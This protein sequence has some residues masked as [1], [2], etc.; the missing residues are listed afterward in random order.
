MGTYGSSGEYITGLASALP[1][2]AS[3][4]T[5]GSGPY[6]HSSEVNPLS[7]LQ[8]PGGGTIADEYYGNSNFNVTLDLTDGNTH[9]VALYAADFDGQNRTETVQAFGPGNVA[10]TA[11]ITVS[12]FTGGDYL[13]FNVSG[14]VTF[15]FTRVAGGSA[16]LS[17][18][19]IDT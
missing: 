7:A 13:I 16:V 1:S 8:K 5:T 15:Q 19:F 11:P 6:V 3:F 10:L 2:Y 14:S 9:Q 18:L 4:S 17:G 12:S